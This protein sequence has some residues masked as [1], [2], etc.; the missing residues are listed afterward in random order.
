MR[1]ST[2]IKQVLLLRI[3]F[4]QFLI[5]PSQIIHKERIDYLHDIRHTG[6]V[7]TL[8]GTHIRIHHRLNH[9]TENIRIDILPIQLAA[10][11]DNLSCLITHLWDWNVFGKKTAIYVRKLIDFLGKFFR[12]LLV[13]HIHHLE[14]LTKHLAEI[15]TTIFLGKLLDK[16]GKEIF[17]KDTCVFSKEAEKQTG[18]KD[19]EVV[20]VVITIIFV[21]STNLIM[22]FGKFLGSLHISWV[23]SRSVYSLHVHQRIEEAKVAVHL[24]EFLLVSIILTSIISQEGFAIAHRNNLWCRLLYLG[25]SLQSLQPGGKMQNIYSLIAEQAFD[26]QAIKCFQDTLSFLVS[27]HILF[28]FTKSLQYLVANLRGRHHFSFERF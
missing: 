2:H 23:F 25:I 10:F 5:F 24:D 16:V 12:T 14:C 8:L 4:F 13:W 11:D 27:R 1:Q 17:R 6:I 3:K 9:T 28:A 20:Q 7:H 19:I 15:G 22:Q 21:I 26:K 18:N